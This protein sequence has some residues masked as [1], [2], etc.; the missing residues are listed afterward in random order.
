M[1]QP[2][3]HH[4]VTHPNTATLTSCGRTNRPA[5]LPALR[6]PSAS[7][8][9]FAAL[10]MAAT[11]IA[12]PPTGDALRP[13]TPARTPSTKPKTSATSP[14]STPPAAAK[15]APRPASPA[16][17]TPD[18][19]D[20]ENY[21]VPNLALQ[22]ALDRA[23]FSP[24]VIDGRP[25]RKTNLALVAFQTARGLPRTGRADEATRA[26]LGVDDHPPTTAY[27]ITQVDR[28]DVGPFPTNWNEKAKLKRLRYES[29]TAL[30][31]ERGHCTRATVARLN[32]GRE[33][34]SLSVGDTVILPTVE[35]SAPL[36]GIH[37]LEVNLT[38]KYIR[39]LD[40]QG[41]PV[42]LV[43]CSIAKMAEKRPH[44][45]AKIT[46]VAFD[47]PYRFDPKMWP[48]VKT[49]KKVLIIPPGP[50][51]PVGVCWIDLSLPGYGIHGTPNPELI[52]K[53]GSHGCI[54]LANWDARRLGKAVRGGMTVTFVGK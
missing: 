41:R 45:T 46:T 25:G 26:A 37:S 38:E 42:A 12:A 19:A 32:P 2:L 13:V 52:G 17:A 51:N 8:T 53:T 15:P 49:V 35:P 39:A 47:P 43:H 10:L 30:L 48:E 50:R 11:A 5:G 27:R 29:L 33:I 1:G 9:A 22:T 34:E 16:S 40:K 31:A 24:G 20:I 6:G 14:K 18:S 21:S 23:G 3:P 28:D 36:R 54:R 44:G 4:I 7:A